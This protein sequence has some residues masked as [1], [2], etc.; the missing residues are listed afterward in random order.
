MQNRP[1]NLPRP[2]YYSLHC[3]MNGMVFIT[4]H[5]SSGILNY[6]HISADNVVNLALNQHIISLHIAIV[7]THWIAKFAF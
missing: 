4:F 7:T 2:I 6:C 1:H 3:Q 5:W